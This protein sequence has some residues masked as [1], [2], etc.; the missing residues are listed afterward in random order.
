M[1]DEEDVGRVSLKQGEKDKH[2]QVHRRFRP[3]PLV[4]CRWSVQVENSHS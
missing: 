2:E 3:L 4:V 1:L